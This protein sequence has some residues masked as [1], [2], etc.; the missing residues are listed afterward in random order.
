MSN[1][2][3]A[4]R[5]LA[6]SSHQAAW[7]CGPRKLSGS[8][9]ENASATL[10]LR[11]SSRRRLGIHSGRAPRGCTAS[12]P[13]TPSIITSRTSCSLPPTS[14]MRCLGEA[15]SARTHS[16]PARVLPAPRP[17]MMSQVTHGA[18]LGASSGGFWWPCANTGQSA[19]SASRSFR[20]SV[21]TNA[22]AL[23]GDKS[24]NFSRKCETEF[25]DV[26]RAVIGRGLLVL[27]LQG[28]EF[29]Q[30]ARQRGERARRAVALSRCGPAPILATIASMAASTLATAPCSRSA[31]GVSGSRLSS[32]PGGG[33]ASPACIGARGGPC[34]AGRS[35]R[36]RSFDLRYGSGWPNERRRRSLDL[37]R[38][39]AR[40]PFRR[41]RRSP[42]RPAP[43]D[44]AIAD[45]A[46]ADAPIESNLIDRLVGVLELVS[47]AASRPSSRGTANRRRWCSVSPIG[48]GFLQCRP[49]AGC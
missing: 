6:I 31:V 43:G 45:R 9:A 13:E 40:R 21:V 19:S 7:N 24:V 17:P 38:G 29:A 8:S 25:V 32:P 2:F 26:G 12:S 48:N 22:A 39:Q 46:G 11:H 33:V 44:P 14:A 35:K 5:H 28:V 16:A 36:R 41:D 34:D 3:S 42:R 1:A 15:A 10:P 20:L 47:N 30:G 18:P 23:R 27:A 4:S 49:S 37:R